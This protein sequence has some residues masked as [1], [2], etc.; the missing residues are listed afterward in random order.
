MIIDS[1]CCNVFFPL[2]TAAKSEKD[3]KSNEAVAGNAENQDS[4]EN[5]D[6][7]ADESVDGNE[8]EG[9]QLSNDPEENSDSSELEDPD[10]PS[11]ES[12]DES[13]LSSEN[14]NEDPAIAKDQGLLKC[15]LPR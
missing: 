15:S 5:E 10:E 8:D 7:N 14:P 3:S 9:D 6:G 12:G 11:E 13:D 2:V 1:T 4:T